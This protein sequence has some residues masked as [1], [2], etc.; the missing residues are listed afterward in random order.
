MVPIHD[1]YLLCR[2]VVAMPPPALSQNK[3]FLYE[4]SGFA[5]QILRAIKAIKIMQ[6]REG[7]FLF[8]SFYVRTSHRFS[9]SSHFQVISTFMFWETTSSPFSLGLSGR[10]RKPREKKWPSEIQFHLSL[11]HQ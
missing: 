1:T 11:V 8:R 2:E 5:R 4:Q 3:K 7:T 10:E 6:K 9:F